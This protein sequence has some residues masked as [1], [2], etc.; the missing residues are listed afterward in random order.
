MD[1]LTGE[2]AAIEAALRSTGD[3]AAVEKL[4]LRGELT[5]QRLDALAAAADRLA[6][7]LRAS[8]IGPC[9]ERLGAPL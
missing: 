9:R 2:V 1:E 5:A 6:N 8:V 7:R 3:G 4:M